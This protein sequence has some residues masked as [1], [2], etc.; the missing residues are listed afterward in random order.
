MYVAKSAV[1]VSVHGIYMVRAAV[2]AAIP[3]DM[4]GH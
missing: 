1:D 3:S 4:F 2:E